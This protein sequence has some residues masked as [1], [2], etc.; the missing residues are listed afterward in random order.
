M[1][2]LDSDK[3][4]AGRQMNT[5]FKYEDT[6]FLSFLSIRSL[7][8]TIIIGSWARDG[9]SSCMEERRVTCNKALPE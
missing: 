5:N 2:I 6:V 8:V 3:L 9:V 4:K 1:S 7:R